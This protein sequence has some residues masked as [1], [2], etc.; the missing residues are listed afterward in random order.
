[1]LAPPVY[2]AE[3]LKAAERSTKLHPHSQNT[4]KVQFEKEITNFKSPK[5]NEV[6]EKKTSYDLTKLVEDTKVSQQTA[7]GSPCNEQQGNS[8][9]SWGKIVLASSLVAVTAFL[10]VKYFKPKTSIIR[11][12]R[13]LFS[14]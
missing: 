9:Y 13:P 12:P 6:Q 5:K 8:T 14:K 4:R 3:E 10:F 7:Y 11:L 2:F 1:L